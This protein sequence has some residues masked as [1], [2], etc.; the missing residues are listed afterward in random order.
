MATR[1]ISADLARALAAP[2]IAPMNR[3]SLVVLVALWVL[4]TAL[5]AAK[6]YHVDDTF[7]LEQAR[8][9]AA[10]PTQ[11]TSG[12]VFWE[13]AAPEP[14][15][16]VGNHS[17]LVPGLQALVIAGVGDTPLSLHLFQAALMAIAIALLHALALRHAP[18]HALTVT[19]LVVVSPAVLAEQNIML[20]VP[21][22][23]AWLACFWALDHPDA[24]RALLGAGVAVS[25][26]LLVKLSSLVLCVVLVEEGARALRAG[27]LTRAQ[28]I[29][30]IALPLGTLVLWGLASGCEVGEVA[31]FSRTREL[32]APTA[33]RPMLETL[34]IALGR[35]ALFAVVLGAVMPAAV[36]LL[37]AWCMVPARRPLLAAFALAFVLLLG[38]ARTVVLALA[39][40]LGLAPL[41][42]EPFAHSCL[43]V[44][45]LLLGLAALVLALGAVRDGSAADRRLGLWCALAAFAAVALAPFLAARHT[46]LLLPPLW[47]LLARRGLLDAA[48]ARRVAVSVALGLGVAVAIADHRLASVYR[49]AAG[50][51]RDRAERL[52]VE[53]LAVAAVEPEPARVLYVG[54][55]GWQ[56]HARAAGLEAYVPGRTRLAVGEV[57]IEPL[58]VHAQPIAPADRDRLVLRETVVIEAGLL[59]LFR[60][61]VDREGL[62]VSWYGLPWSL[63][64]E[65]VERFLLWQVME[66]LRP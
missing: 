25:L 20:D 45:D 23:V 59:D 47:M 66:P 14:L 18:R 4:A 26:A 32:F 64:T 49:D 19:V 41:A 42:N 54:H 60:T 6:P 55:W 65:P 27:R 62:Y 12:L 51:L 35:S 61:S 37:P 56:E 28:L 7:Y 31:F 1:D 2:T 3:R 63:R 22:L 13:S 36:V 9:I 21:L 5:N 44:I 15:H 53:A 40:T 33:A 16:R 46:A 52:G 29:A 11:P 57:L 17:P 8:W 24:P 34:G 38:L 10:H 50:P 39:D 43:R 48:G 58:G 30:S